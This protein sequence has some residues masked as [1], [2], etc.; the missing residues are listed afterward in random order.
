MAEM[1][2]TNSWSDE[3]ASLMDDDPVGFSSSTTFEVRRSVYAPPPPS[4]E[5]PVVVAEGEESLKEQA[6]GFLMA[7]CEIL[8]EL[9][10]GCRDILRQNFLNEDSF[11][12]RNFALPCAKVSKRLSFLNDFLP[13]DRDPFHAWSIVV[14][15]FV[16]ALAAISVDPNHDA[17]TEVMKVRTHPPS[18]RRI[19]LPDGRNMSY[20]E[21]GVSAGRARFS[22]VAPHSLLSSR[23]AGIPGVKASLLEDYGVR[24]VTYDLPGFGESDPHPTRSLNSS[25][26]D[27]LHLANAA[28]VTDKFW[29]LCHSSGCVHAWAS[30]RYIPD[31]I[32]GAVMLAPMINPYEPGMVKDEMKRTWVKW[33]PKRKF[34]Y[35]L[36]HRF[37]KLLSFFYKKNFLPENHDQI[38]KQLYYSLGKKDEILIEE[39]EFEEFWQRDV[40]ESVRQGSVQPFIEEV[41]LQVSKWGFGIEELRVQR[42]CQ[43]RSLLLWLKSMYSQAECELEGFPGLIHIWQ[44]MDDRVVP[45]SMMEYIGRVLPEAIIHKLQNEGHFSYFFFCDEC[46]S[47]IF[48]TVF[49]T[50]QGPIQE[51]QEEIAYE[52]NTEDLIQQR[53][54]DSD[55]A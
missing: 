2:V 49:G 11:L 31:R 38:D 3:L 46:H 26:T 34:M 17:L 27:M 45:P 21:Q 41:I 54:S 50:P 7:W 52:E 55:T 10:R 51:P 4:V 6:M 47:K 32:A 19:L 25:A 5:E 9:G 13:E 43:T 48:S 42:K 29:V 44:G 15:V 8:M 40:E 23:L 33:L 12:F 28:N 35:I 39:P 37:P 20:Y 30:L 22:L 1:R 18:A 24:L 36:A 16:L 53:T 14:F